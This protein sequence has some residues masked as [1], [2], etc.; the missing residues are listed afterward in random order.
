MLTKISSALFNGLLL[1]AGHISGWE[2][3][4]LVDEEIVKSFPTCVWADIVSED[5]WS[6]DYRELSLLPF[7]LKTDH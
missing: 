5:W 3:V 6:H 4:V 7:H 2:I 1:L